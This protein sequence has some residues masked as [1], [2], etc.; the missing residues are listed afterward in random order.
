MP[1]LNVLVMSHF[2]DGNRVFEDYCNGIKAHS[3]NYYYVDYIHQYFIDGKDKFEKQIEELVVDKKIDCIFFIWWSCDLTFDLRFIEKLSSLTTIVI[4]YFDTEY[5]F[6]GVDR[7]YAQL[8]DLVILPDCLARYKYEQLNINALTTFA[9]YDRNFYIKNDSVNKSI[10]VSFVGNLKQ[11]NRKEYV[12]YLKMHGISVKTYGVGSDNGFVS[13]EE[14]V[15]IFNK[16][17]INLNFTAISDSK[18][19]VIKPPIINQRI[20]QSKGR[21]IEIALSGGFV[22]SEYAPGIEE[23]F[24]IGREIDVF[25]TKEELLEKIE[26][27]LSNENKRAEIAARGYAMALRSY[28]SVSGFENVFNRIKYLGRSKNKTIYIDREFSDNFISYRFFYILQFLLNGRLKNIPAELR[29]ILKYKSI[30]LKKSFHFAVKGFL[31]Y[32]RAHPRLESKLKL[33]KNKL[34]IQLKY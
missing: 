16:S 27:Y 22:L 10:D 26:Y 34:K 12:D 5:F 13:F 31:Y 14:M 28:D 8:A 24:S 4:N 19:Y 32:M 20:K 2:I 21:P 25:N 15:N 30:N 17:K 9:M 3:G 29:I 1:N 6:E 7:Y 23:M 11:S 33:L 18:N